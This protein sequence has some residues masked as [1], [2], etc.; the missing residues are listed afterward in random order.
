MDSAVKSLDN[1]KAIII[2]A[3]IYPDREVKEA[4]KT[5]KTFDVP[6][7]VI[8]SSKLGNEDFRNNGDNRCY[9]CKVQL[10]SSLN[11]DKTILEGTNASEVKGHRPGLKAVKKYARAPL[12][13]TGISEQDVRDILRWRRHDVWD[14]PSFACLASRFPSGIK[15]TEKKLKVVE[16]IEEKIFNLGVEQLRV[17]TL[18]ETARIEVWT[19]D[20]DKIVNNREKIIMWCKDEGFKHVSLDL[21]GYRT[22]SISGS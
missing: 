9:H 6:F 11:H 2:D 8:E 17:R 14:K 13:E 12:L 10:F 7:E 15:L 20:L 4:V 18:G 5:V 19:E 22:G 21:Q 3:E 1:V 16:N